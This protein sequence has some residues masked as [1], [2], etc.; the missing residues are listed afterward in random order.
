MRRHR[1]SLREKSAHR[2]E[3]ADPP[4][5]ELPR[6]ADAARR[7]ARRPALRPARNPRPHAARKRRRCLPRGS[8]RRSL[9]EW[10]RLAGGDEVRPCLRRTRHSRGGRARQRSGAE[11]ATPSARLWRTVSHK[12]R[13]AMR[14]WRRHDD[15]AAPHPHPIAIATLPKCRPLARCAKAA[16]ASSKA[17]VLSITGRMPLWAIALTIA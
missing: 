12:R 11:L 2:H 5:Q 17:K 16:L 15:R 14:N 4:H 13:P 3:D 10:L 6:G 7:G 1:Q 9:P 8:R